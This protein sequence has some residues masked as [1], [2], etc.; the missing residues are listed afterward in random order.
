V[1]QSRERFERVMAPKVVG[2]WNLHLITAQDPLDYF[3]LFSSTSAVFGNTGQGNYAAANVFLDTLAHYRRARGL[4][5]LSVNWSAVADVGVV[6]R[7]SA[8]RAHLERI[9]LLP[10]ESR[11]LL[12]GLGLLLRQDAVQTTIMRLDWSRVGAHALA[13]LS[14]CLAEIA[15]A[16]GPADASPGGR[17]QERPLRELLST[18]TAPARTELL[19]TALCEQISK[20]LGLAPSQLDP[21]VPLTGVGLDSLVA[22]DLAARL[23]RELGVDISVFKL[24]H[25]VTVSNLLTEIQERLTGSANVAETVPTLPRSERWRS[26]VID[27][28]PRDFSL[29]GTLGPQKAV[30]R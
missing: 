1:Q 16:A 26:Q 5:A 14:P 2:A 28:A 22:I 4:P 25:G 17:G 13:A 15:R 9:G 8:V 21:E 18:M 12:R 6:A 23:K 30:D 27:K 24:L 3:V 20:S 19:T 10:L 11:W 7:D 29:S